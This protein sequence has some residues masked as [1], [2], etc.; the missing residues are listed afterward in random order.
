V[1]G[2]ATYAIIRKYDPA[3]KRPVKDPV[4]RRFGY[5]LDSVKKW[6]PVNWQAFNAQAAEIES[7]EKLTADLVAF[8]QDLGKDGRVN[9]GAHTNPVIKTRIDQWI[10]VRSRRLSARDALNAD[11]SLLSFLKVTCQSDI[12]AAQQRI[13]YDYFRRQLEDEQKERT[14]IAGVFGKIVESMRQ[15]R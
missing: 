12:T 7:I 2:V 1:I 15:E 3:T 13:T 6:E 9:R 14:E 4:I 5:R 10:D 11:Q 8:L